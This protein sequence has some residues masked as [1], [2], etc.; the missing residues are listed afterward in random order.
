VQDAIARSAW[1]AQQ[2]IER[3]DDVVE[4]VNRFVEPERAEPKGAPD[5]RALAK[6]QVGRLKA[7]RAGRDAPKVRAATRA[8]GA[9]AQDPGA[10]LMEP[11]LDAVRARATLGEISAALES[12]WGRHDHA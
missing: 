3:G 7:A 1:A 4:G 9:A 2:A 6:K 10:W 12:V 11:I 8:L 5:Y